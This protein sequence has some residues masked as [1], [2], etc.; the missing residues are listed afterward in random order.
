MHLR[1]EY[2]FF[3]LSLSMGYACVQ[4]EKSEENVAKG[5]DFMVCS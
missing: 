1:P 4:R 3:S 2:L 5:S